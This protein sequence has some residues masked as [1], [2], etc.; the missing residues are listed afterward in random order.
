MTYFCDMDK[1]QQEKFGDWLMD[2]AKYMFTA[3]VLSSFLT[4]MKNP[5]IMGIVIIISFVVLYIGML[6]VKEDK[7]KK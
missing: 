6:L 3:L 2:V 7:K 1:K 5:W 4:D